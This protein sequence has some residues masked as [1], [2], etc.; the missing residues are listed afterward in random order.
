MVVHSITWPHEVVYSSVGKPAVYQELSVPTFMQ[1]YLVVMH[2]QD[3]KNQGYYDSPLRRFD[4]RLR[5][6][7]VG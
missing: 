7:W 5:P 6:L 1:G 2:C 4:V 3:T